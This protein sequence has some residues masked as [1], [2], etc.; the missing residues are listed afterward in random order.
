MEHASVLQVKDKTRQFTVAFKGQVCQARRAALEKQYVCHA[1]HLLHIIWRDG[2]E[3]C[4]F[5]AEAIL[6][7]AAQLPANIRAC[8]SAQGVSLIPRILQVS[9]TAT[10]CHAQ[11]L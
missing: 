4:G 5:R 10:E 2:D 8:S 6:P 9:Y 7:A 1:R 11:P 3:F